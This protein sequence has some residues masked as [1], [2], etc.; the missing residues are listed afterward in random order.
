MKLTVDWLWKFFFSILIEAFFLPKMHFQFMLSLINCCW[1]K[2]FLSFKFLVPWWLFRKRSASKMFMLLLALLAPLLSLLNIKFLF[3]VVFSFCVIE[4]KKSKVCIRWDIECDVFHTRLM[5]HWIHSVF[6]VQQQSVVFLYLTVVVD[7]E[8]FNLLKSDQFFWYL[9]K[10]L[11]FYN[12]FMF[13][14]ILKSIFHFVFDNRCFL[15]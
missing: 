11:L 2:R 7:I 12:K 5:F 15:F 3:V 10:F 4:S 14:N 8:Y 9:T 6:F 1:F 13:S